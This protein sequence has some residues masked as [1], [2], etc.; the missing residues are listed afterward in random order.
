MPLLFWLSDRSDAKSWE[1]RPFRTDRLSPTLLAL[2]GI[3]W[4]D[5]DAN[6]IFLDPAYVWEKPEIPVVDPE[7]DAVTARETQRRASAAP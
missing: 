3:R 2:A 1:N 6:R 5:E 4:K 7:L